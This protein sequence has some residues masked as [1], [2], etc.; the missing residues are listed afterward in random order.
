VDDD[1]E[2]TPPP[3][4][5]LPSG[6]RSEISKLDVCPNCGADMPD[7]R[8]VVCM[9]CGF[10]LKKLRVIKTV[11]GAKAEKDE[12]EPGEAPPLCRPLPGDPWVPAAVAGVALVLLVVGHLAGARGLFVTPVAED[13]TA[14]AIAGGVR[15][16]TLMRSLV[17]LATW[18]ACGVAALATLAR[19]IEVRF[20]DATLALLRSLA[21]VTV[22]RLVAFLDFGTRSVEWTVEAAGQAALAFLALLVLFRLSPRNAGLALGAG[23]VAFLVLWIGA[24]AITWATG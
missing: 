6:A 4:G 15:F 14:E 12:D 5:D 22:M 13:G 17:L 8:T 10:D 19:M 18:T 23:L 1:D 2:E 7:I 11:T 24:V 21:V 20:G 9:R 3:S 16:T